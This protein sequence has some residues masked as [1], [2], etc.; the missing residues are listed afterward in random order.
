MIVLAIIFGRDPDLTI[1][2]QV[3]TST[4]GKQAWLFDMFGMS[5]ITAV[6]RITTTIITTTTTTIT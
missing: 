3:R 6:T 2:S 1:M 4:A 5:Q